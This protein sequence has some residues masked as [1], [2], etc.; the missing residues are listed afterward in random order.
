MRS[1][2]KDSELATPPFSDVVRDIDMMIASLGLQS[3]R[4]YMDQHHWHDESQLARAADEI[5]PGLKLENVAAHSW[6]VADA[7]MLVASNFSDLDSRHA[8]E[9][10]ILHDKLELFTGDLDPVGPDGQGN[11]S[12]AFDNAARAR[13]QEL[14]LAALELYIARLPASAGER[15]R[16]LILESI[17]GLSEEARFVKG[18]DKLQ[19]LTF[20]LAK[21][22][23]AMTDE[24]LIF[25]LRYSAKAKEYFPRLTRH[26]AELVSR[27]L[28]LIAVFRRVSVESLLS[29]LPTAA[30]S[31]IGIVKP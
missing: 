7:T 19:A 23:G 14:E 11:L 6:H 15:Q 22:A 16:A 9:L 13:K 18:I 31:V 28:T 8:V 12:H 20:V 21:K 1:G 10:A 30:L 17:Y 25:T 27:L 26:H 29:R 5:E 24:H 4:R 2:S 3:I